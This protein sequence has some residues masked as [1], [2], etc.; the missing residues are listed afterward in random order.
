M[1]RLTVDAEFISYW[2][3]LIAYNNFKFFSLF[4]VIMAKELS[5]RSGIL[6]F[7]HICILVLRVGLVEF[8]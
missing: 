8:D 6:V 7:L 3:I 2:S 1:L 4:L 5:P